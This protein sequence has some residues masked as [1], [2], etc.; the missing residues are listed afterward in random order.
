[1]SFTTAWSTNAVAICKACG[2][3]KVERIERSTRY[4]LKSEKEFTPQILE[5]FLAEVLASDYQL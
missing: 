3:T 1:M 2:V 4:L 5:S